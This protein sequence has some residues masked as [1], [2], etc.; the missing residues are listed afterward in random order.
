MSKD[1]KGGKHKTPTKKVKI[2]V[3]HDDKLI[4]L[5][6]GAKKPPMT[7][8]GLMEYLIDLCGEF[9]FEKTGWRERFNEGL[10]KIDQ[11]IKRKKAKIG[12]RYSFLDDIPC[13]LRDYLGED[14]APKKMGEGWYCLKKAPTIKKLGSGIAEAAGKICQGCQIRDGALEDS[15]ILKEQKTLGRVVPFPRCKRGAE[16]KDDMTEFF[17]P[18]IGRWR[19]IKERK[20]KTDPQPCHA[21]GSPPYQRCPEIEWTQ[22][23]IKGELPDPEK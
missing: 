16:L 1:R 2:S 18:E 17:C 22:I 7:K 6:Q 5:A 12:H 20:K 13:P 14:E 11:D 9:H 23:V 3:P 8:K 4:A 19:P 15:R 10:D 21:R